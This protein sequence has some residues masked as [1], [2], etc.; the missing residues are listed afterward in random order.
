LTGV[1]PDIRD[2]HKFGVRCH[3]CT[4]HDSRWVNK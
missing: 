2:V 3:R 4:N 1:M